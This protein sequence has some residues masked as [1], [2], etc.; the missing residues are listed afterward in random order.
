LLENAIKHNVISV[1]KPLLIEISVEK[2]NF[3][4]I[5]NNLQRKNQVQDSTGVGLEN[6]KTRYVL[7]SDKRVEVIVTNES[8]V[9][10]LPL[11]KIENQLVTA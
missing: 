2:E 8:F 11:L 5:K 1:A 6:I 10:V 7:V 3:L 9:V 4:I